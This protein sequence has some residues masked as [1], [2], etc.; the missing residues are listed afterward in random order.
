MKPSELI[1]RVAA[2]SKADQ[3]QRDIQ[4]CIKSLEKHRTWND[5]PFG[6]MSFAKAWFEPEEVPEE[7]KKYI[8]NLSMEAS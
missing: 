7:V 1:E 6:M 5:C 8:N 2:G 3:R 4:A